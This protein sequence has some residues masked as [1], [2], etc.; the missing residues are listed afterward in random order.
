MNMGGKSDAEI[1]LKLVSIEFL[2]TLLLVFAGCAATV[3]AAKDSSTYNSSGVLQTAL[4]WG[5]VY[6]ALTQTFSHIGGVHMNPAITVAFF[7]TKRISLVATLVYIATQIVAAIVGAAIVDSFSGQ[8]RLYNLGGTKMASDVSSGDAFGLEFIITFVVVFVFFA[9]LDPKVRF[10]GS[11]HLSTIHFGGVIALV[12]LIAIPFTGCSINPA[13]SFGPAVITN[14][15][16]NHWVYWLGPLAGGALGGLLYVLWYAEG[17]MRMTF[18]ELF[19]FSSARS[20]ESEH[21][22][23]VVSSSMASAAV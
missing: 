16:N 21:A 5:F 7:V 17:S 15:W 1:S 22:T 20:S 13:R 9:L 8:K 4:A 19:G 18:G 6:A 3:A 12:H 14:T 2:G 10:S 23:V 11:V